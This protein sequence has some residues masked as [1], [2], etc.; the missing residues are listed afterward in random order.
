VRRCLVAVTT[1]W[2]APKSWHRKTSQVMMRK[3]LTDLW[4]R[5]GIPIFGTIWYLSED[6]VNCKCSKL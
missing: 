2:G 3:V 5:L 6:D 1:W 4:W